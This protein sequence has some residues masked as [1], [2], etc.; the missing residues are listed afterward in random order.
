M[1]NNND[2]N[3][4]YRPSDTLVWWSDKVYILHMSYLDNVIVYQ[5]QQVY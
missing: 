4:S 1:D 3:G 2:N 5:H